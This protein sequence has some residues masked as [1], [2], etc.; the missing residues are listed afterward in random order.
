[1]N[2][3]E[4][5]EKYTLS[6]DQFFGKEK[7]DGSLILSRLTSIPDGFSPNV[8]GTLSLSRL[9]SIP[10]GFNPNVGGSLIL[11]SLASIPD[12]FNPS[13]VG[14]LWLKNMTIYNYNFC[15]YYCSDYKI[16]FFQKNK[17]N[18]NKKI[19][20]SAINNSSL[21]IEI[22]NTLKGELEGEFISLFK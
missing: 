18:K 4:F 5:I 1:M 13:V 2:K 20:D 10:D 17:V 14:N 16:K 7:I 11:S 21:L 15:S 3:Q 6:E 8:G 19:I 12:G 22:K 9:T